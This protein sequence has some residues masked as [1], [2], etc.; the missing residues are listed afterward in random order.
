VVLRVM[1]ITILSHEAFHSQ[2]T[3][4]ACCDEF[5]ESSKVVIEA[6]FV[7]LYTRVKYIRLINNIAFGFKLLG[8]FL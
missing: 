4:F 1:P 8:Q 3:V 5:S 7:I 6:T 2:G